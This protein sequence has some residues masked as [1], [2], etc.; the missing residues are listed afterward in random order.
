MTQGS[1]RNPAP[2]RDHGG[3]PAL[4]IIKPIGTVIACI[5]F[6]GAC[7]ASGR[8]PSPQAAKASG[9][10][11][12]ATSV[13]RPATS[14]PTASSAPAKSQYW[15]T[16]RLEKLGFSVFA[17]PV[18]VGDFTVA[19]LAGASASLSQ[20]RGKVV[21]LNFWATWCPSCRKEM[22]SIEALWGKMKGKPFT[23]M[24]ISLGETRNA[25]NKFVIDNKYSY[26]I[27]LDPENKLGSAF[28]VNGIPT[29]YIIDTRGLAIAGTVGAVDYG[30]E[31][32]RNLLSE[33][34]LR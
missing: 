34:S 19:S 13:E 5:V 9:Q 27:F 15:Y 11:G 3:S 10:D 26:P 8:I 7:G 29:T 33:L 18:D 1:S 23:I 16:D 20:M 31:E 12:S 24:A 17:Q 32:M 21:L 6:L 14:T 25:V 30:S 4:R 28:G 2:T 22:P